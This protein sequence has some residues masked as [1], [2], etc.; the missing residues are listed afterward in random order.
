MYYASA[1][2]ITIPIDPAKLYTI[3]INSIYG[4]DIRL[5]I[6]K[7]AMTY[8]SN[9]PGNGQARVEYSNGNFHTWQSG[10]GNWYHMINYSI[11]W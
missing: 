9:V 2:N 1:A 11:L 4:T 10:S 7:G 3:G 5:Y 8:I 6:D